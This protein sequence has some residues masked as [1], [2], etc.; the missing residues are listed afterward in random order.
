MSPNR[1]SDIEVDRL[2]PYAFMAVVGKRVIHPGGRRS[3]AEMCQLARF[4]PGQQVLEV[5]CGVATTAIEVARRFGCHVTAVDIDPLMLG[6]ATANV[7]AAGVANV[8][9]A[10]AD[11]QAL[12]F[13]DATFD[14]VFI[15]GV[16]MFVDRQRATQEVVRVCRPGGLVL[17]HE[18]I[19]RRPPTAAIRRVF[20]GELC[21][22]I[23]F[24]TAEDWMLLYQHAGLTAIQHTTG[25]FAMMTPLGMVRDEGVGNLLAML[26]CV[27]RRR[28]YRRKMAWLMSRMLR[29]MPYLGY[30]VLAGTKPIE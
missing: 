19:Y 10:K 22:G 8:T 7:R 3:T 29:V 26:A 24:D 28:A 21:P 14:R 30:I 9:V 1:P 2:D 18:F 11:I 25:P 27:V 16:T 5:G 4:Q 20:C 17:D 6:R 12:E 15:E 23:S 13:P